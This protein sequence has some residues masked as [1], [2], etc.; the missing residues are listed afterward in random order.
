MQRLREARQKNGLTQK[1]VAI[2][3]GVAPPTVSMWESGA[4]NPNRENLAKLS[5][6][7]G[8]TVDYLMGIDAQQSEAET[9]EE[10][11]LLQLYRSLNPEGKARL[12]EQAADYASL[13]KWTKKKAA[14]AAI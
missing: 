1:Y 12:L 6:L 5:E 8:V 7:Y 3:V 10:R 4:K 11:H 2:S 13:E 9:A 14:G